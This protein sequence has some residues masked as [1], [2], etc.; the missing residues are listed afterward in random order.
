MKDKDIL[1]HYDILAVHIYAY[2]HIERDM[3]LLSEQIGPQERAD[4]VY[5]NMFFY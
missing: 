3:S 4:T 1:K 5:R 2:T